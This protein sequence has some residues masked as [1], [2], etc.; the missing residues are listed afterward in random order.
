MYN[1]GMNKSE[2]RRNYNHFRYEV[3]SGNGTLYI[4]D[5]HKK[6]ITIYKEECK[7][8]LRDNYVE[9]ALLTNGWKHLRN[10]EESLE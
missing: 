7:H 5:N 6:I 9:D 1:R 8:E 4:V 10:I 2:L 3:L